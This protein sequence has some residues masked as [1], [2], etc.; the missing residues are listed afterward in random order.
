MIT[1]IDD[2]MIEITLTTIAAYGSFIL[3]EDL[4]HSGVIAMVTAGMICGSYGQ[5][6]GMPIDTGRCSDFLGEHGV[7]AQLPRLPAHRVRR[8]PDGAR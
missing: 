2:A 8:R 4:H 3:S 5:R 7:C 1:H 6:V